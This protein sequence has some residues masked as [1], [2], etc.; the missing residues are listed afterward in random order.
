MDLEQVAK[1]VRGTLARKWFKHPDFEDAV[2]EAII[3]AWRDIE[4]GGY[5]FAHVVNR[6]ALQGKK[7]LADKRATITG[8]ARRSKE[9]TVSAQGEA[10][11]EKI[12]MFIRDYVDIHEK[13]PTNKEIAAAVGVSNSTV[14]THRK[15]GYTNVGA[16]GG[17]TRHNY[18]ESSLESYMTAAD[19]DADECPLFAQDS[20]E[21]SLIEDLDFQNLLA[22]LSEE[23]AKALTLYVMGYIDREIAEA[24]G[25][26][27]HPQPMGNKIKKRALKEARR[28]LTSE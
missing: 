13:M 26:D 6:A 12:N 18:S 24:F 4:T 9:G 23:S 8:K 22:S 1:V 17:V 19:I 14:I 21:D 28:V 15:R 25:Y 3:H 27:K 7:L 16:D 20:F 11:R 2:Q 10:T 5:T